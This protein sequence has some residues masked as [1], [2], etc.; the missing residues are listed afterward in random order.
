MSTISRETYRSIGFHCT[1]KGY[2]IFDAPPPAGKWKH[3]CRYVDTKQD[4]GAQS[5]RD[6]IDRMCND[7]PC[8]TGDLRFRCEQE[9]K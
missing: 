4:E 9:R 5:M 6:A 1:H 7:A 2:W 3:W 8:Y